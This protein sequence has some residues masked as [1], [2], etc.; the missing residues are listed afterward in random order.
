M[1][2]IKIELDD[3]ECVLQNAAIVTVDLDGNE[4]RLVEMLAGLLKTSP[5]LRELVVKALFV[6][7]RIDATLTDQNSN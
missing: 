1:S 7:A 5:E 4:R 3:R 6:S 2:R